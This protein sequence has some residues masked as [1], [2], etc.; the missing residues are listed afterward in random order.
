MPLVVGSEAVGS[1]LRKKQGPKAVKSDADTGRPETAEEFAC[2]M[3]GCVQFIGP[4][5]AQEGRNT[6]HPNAESTLSNVGSNPGH[7]IGVSEQAGS[8]K[9]NNHPPA[10]GHDLVNVENSEDIDIMERAQGNTATSQSGNEPWGQSTRGGQSGQSGFSLVD[11]VSCTA[12]GIEF[13][14]LIRN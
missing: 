6:T 3:I 7:E 1:W 4:R 10:Q 14:S 9:S 12:S 8:A 13:A 2:R 5:L 11:I